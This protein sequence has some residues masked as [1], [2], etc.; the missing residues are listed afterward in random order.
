MSDPRYQAGIAQGAAL[1][2]DCGLG[3]WPREILGLGPMQGAHPFVEC[4]ACPPPDPGR[5]PQSVKLPRST[6]VRYGGN[7]LCFPCAVILAS[8][9]DEVARLL[10]KRSG[11]GQL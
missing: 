10:S 1:S 3:G 5:H 8:A 6:F 9:P 7:P 11:K 4:C 2:R